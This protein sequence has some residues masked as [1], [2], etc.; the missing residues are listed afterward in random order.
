MRRRVVEILEREGPISR[1][2]IVELLGDS[3]VTNRDNQFVPTTTGTYIHP[4]VIKQIRIWEEAPLLD[5]LAVSAGYRA[6]LFNTGAVGIRYEGLGKYV[7]E[8]GRDLADS[9]GISPKNLHYTCQCLLDE[10]RVRSALSRDLL[11]YY[12]FHPSFP[13]YLKDAKW[14]RKIKRPTGYPCTV[15]GVP[16]GNIDQDEVPSGIRFTLSGVGKV[17]VDGSRRWSVSSGGS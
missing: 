14:E 5:N 4:E 13:S 3:A 10:M 16:I 9:L 7:I 11:R 2:R 6:S 15:D 12:P 8:H 17:P 1:Q